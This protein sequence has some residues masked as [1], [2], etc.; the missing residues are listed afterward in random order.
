MSRIQR[1]SN[2]RIRIL[3]AALALMAGF[4]VTGWCDAQGKVIKK[5][6]RGQAIG[7]IKWKPASKV[8]V[9]TD[10]Q[11]V[12]MTIPLSEVEQVVVKDPPE[13]DAG[14]KLVEG[15]QAALAIANLETIVKNYDGMGVDTRAA[16]WLAEAYLKTG[17]PGK[18][19]EMCERVVSANPRAAGDPDFAG[20]YWEALLGADQS[21]KLKKALGEAIATGPR[22]LVAKALIKRG[23]MER[24]QGKEKAYMEAALVD[25]YLRVVV[26]FQD[27]KEA[28][29]EALYGAVQVFR[30]LGQL[31]YA[32][33]LSDKLLA[34]FPDD[35]YSE[36]IKS[37]N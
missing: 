36:R 7:S 35:P 16:R 24:K 10:Q 28:Q 27:V 32:K 15:G 25:G 29:P 17:V 2:L 31:G 19:V 26:L 11:G 5:G 6:G 22:P 9:V 1:I 4:A 20:I 34:E 18:A 23:D 33:R 37:N 14:R 21:A 12:S 13:L 30:E 3:V 8:Y